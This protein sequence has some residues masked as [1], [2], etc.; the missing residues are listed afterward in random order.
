MNKKSV[1]EIDV[2][3]KRVLVRVDF[4]VPLNDDGEVS[5]DTRIIASLPTLIYLIE[6]QAKVII[7]SHLG[8]P[9]GKFDERY[10]LDPAA[11]RLAELLKKPVQK[12]NDCIGDEP[13]AAI[14]SMQ[15]GDVLL[16]E[17][18]RFY[19]G[20][21]KN[22]EKFARGLAEL[23]DIYVNDAFGTA[24][25]AHASTEGVA[26][27]LPAVAGFLMQKEIN[28]LGKT[29]MQPEHPFFIILGGAKISDKIGIID[30]LLGKVDNLII[31]GGM[32]NTFLRA[33]GYGLGKSLIE[34][35]KVEF[36]GEL[37]AKIKD[38]G[39]KLM[40]P[41]D[42]VVTP[43][44]EPGSERKVVSINEVPE[45]WMALDIGPETIG[46]Y[47]KAVSVAKTV[48]WN[49]PMG[50]FEMPPFAQGT[51]SL[52]RALVESGAITVV[53]GGDTA[54]AVEKAGIADRITHISTGGGASLEFME[55]KVLPGVAALLDD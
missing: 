55:G 47:T 23:A 30:N 48:I 22:E 20:E 43:A 3:G 27:L 11:R 38:Q 44:A 50:V 18:V 39:L 21:E 52:A 46:V 14:S 2:T 49:G 24:H 42:L 40:L 51:F 4:N 35:D 9:K 15:P 10:R 17:N 1:S 37:A 36:A 45:D 29:I 16:L 53:G 26:H 5:D 34:A 41:V 6:K 54:S 8:R 13:K 19:P 12:V 32:A 33:A 7:V 31:G 28:M 25:R